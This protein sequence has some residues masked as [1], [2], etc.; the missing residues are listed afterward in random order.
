MIKT[1]VVILAITVA[2]RA[3]R[4]PIPDEITIYKLPQFRSYLVGVTCNRVKEMEGVSKTRIK[5]KSE[6][7]ELIGLLEDSSNFN[8]YK[9]TTDID[10]R[11]LI[12]YVSK[13][14][15]IKQICWSRT[16]LIQKEGKTYSY[17]QKI[18]DYLLKQKLIIKLKEQQ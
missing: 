10:S 5:N 8:L 6:I 1:L 11:I 9:D 13:G 4:T 18:E 14:K 2:C 12:E 17:S 7:R 15:V 16:E 3:Q